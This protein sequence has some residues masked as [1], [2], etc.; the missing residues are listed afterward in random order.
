VIGDA[1]GK[2]WRI[3]TGRFAGWE[4]ARV[5]HREELGVGQSVAGPALI[6]EKEC[7]IYIGPDASATVDATGSVLMEVA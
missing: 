7:A 1:A 4:R 6:Q 3:Y 2:E 5:V